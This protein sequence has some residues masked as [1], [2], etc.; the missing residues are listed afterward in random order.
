MR[1]RDSLHN[2]QNV[3][4]F[5]Y[6][7]YS[8]IDCAIAQPTN[9]LLL[10]TTNNKNINRNISCVRCVLFEALHQIVNK[11]WRRWLQ[12]SQVLEHRQMCYVV[13]LTDRFQTGLCR[14]V[15]VACTSTKNAFS[16]GDFYSIKIRTV[17][18]ELPFERKQQSKLGN[19]ESGFIEIRPWVLLF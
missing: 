12:C 16:N 19:I 5:S 1:T 9:Q 4:G 11:Q 6:W 2:N 18:F 17:A 15:G 10:T 13:L 8:I 3:D 14:S 7:N